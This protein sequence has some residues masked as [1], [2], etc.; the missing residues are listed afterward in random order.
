MQYFSNFKIIA[1]VF[2]FSSVILFCLPF[3]C[4]QARQKLIITESAP[5]FYLKPKNQGSWVHFPFEQYDLDQAPY[6]DQIKLESAKKRFQQFQQYQKGNGYNAIVLGDLTR[7]LTF[8]QSKILPQDSVEMQ[9]AKIYQD[10]FAQLTTETD[11]RTFIS[12]D[13][14]ISNPYLE[15][16]VG[17]MQADN[18]KLHQINQSAI[19]EVFQGLPELDGM[20]IRTQEGG[21][22]Y[23]VNDFYASKLVYQDAASLRKMIR[24]ILPIFQEL[25]KTLIIRTWSA[26]VGELGDLSYN[27]ATFDQVF[28]PFYDQTNLIISVKYG[29]G[30]FWYYVKPNPLLGRG[31]L[32]QLVEFQLRREYE[33]YGLIGNFL[34][35]YY[36]S[37]IQNQLKKNPNFAGIYNW[38][39]IGG[40]DQAYNPVLFS[41]A[42]LWTE[43]DN[44]IIPQF[45]NQ[46][47]N[48]N[49]EQVLRK[50]LAQKFSRPLL[51]SLVDYLLD[52]RNIVK[53]IYYVESFARQEQQI[54]G[55]T[56]PKVMWISWNRPL[57]NYFGLINII[58]KTENV[59]KEIAKTRQAFQKFQKHRQT[60]LDQIQ[61]QPK[62]ANQSKKST[63]LVENLNYQHD[64]LEILVQY[65]SVFLKYYQFLDKGGAEN[66]QQSLGLF[67]ELKVN[68]G[69]FQNKYQ[70][71][72]T[73][74]ALEFEDIQAFLA[75]VESLKLRMAL[76]FIATIG[77]I[78]L[79]TLAFFK[80]RKSDRPVIRWFIL[81][82]FLINLINTMALSG[83]QHG[84]LLAVF[85]ALY[86][87]FLVI[88]NQVGY[89][90]LRVKPLI[91]YKE[92]S[93]LLNLSSISAL[94]A[95]VNI[96]ALGFVPERIWLRIYE[97]VFFNFHGYFN[98]I[99]TLIVFILYYFIKLLIRTRQFKINGLNLIKLVIAD[100]IT[101]LIAV[102]LLWELLIAFFPYI[103]SVLNLFPSVLS[104]H[105]VGDHLVQDLSVFH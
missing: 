87:L 3:G 64:L 16:Y 79:A 54:Q 56:L 27:P 103:N 11:L 83:F 20:I 23:A 36:G 95:F 90:V 22:N 34:G 73:F 35:Q 52:S 68:I 29:Q 32:P 47:Q 67:H 101:F 57:S 99:I 93:V 30:D 18:P 37:I 28:K 9:R 53:N 59:D 41:Q 40:W 77:F 75:S 63:Y 1:N 33:G 55:V 98:L 60:I 97:V 89:H 12:A 65:K 66:Y 94:L 38:V 17:E 104:S 25:D 10:F 42:G 91:L 85:I 51:E 102:T 5:A 69:A 96:L 71:N 24:E 88:I 78:L 61:N 72:L 26:G 31:E 46:E 48:I 14:Q 70:A 80:Y 8:K 4:I 62:E 86:F 2:I 50:S 43:L 92:R 6:V 76:N 21:K 19:R 84:F 100:L 45:L 13:F 49:I 7:V 58:K 81:G 82:F 15:N 44:T 105:G 74:D 39:M